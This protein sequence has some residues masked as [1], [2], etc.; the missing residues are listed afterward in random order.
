MKL[1][2]IID[3]LNR[4]RLANDL[5]A[6]SLLLL[7]SLFLVLLIL[8]TPPSPFLLFFS[9]LSGFFFYLFYKLFSFFP[10]FQSYSR[11]RSGYLLE[12]KFPVIK[13]KLIPAL[14]LAENYKK[15]Q[16]SKEAYSLTLINAAINEAQE[17]LKGLPINAIVNRPFLKKSA[18]AF[19]MMVWVIALFAFFFPKNFLFSFYSLFSPGRIPLEISISPREI[20]TLPNKEVQIKIAIRAPYQFSSTLLYFVSSSAERKVKLPLKKNQAVYKFYPKEPLLYYV[21][22]FN[23]LSE[24]G[25]IRINQPLALSRLT[26]F[27]QPPLYTSL[28]PLRI[29]FPKEISCLKGSEIK[30]SGA[31]NQKAD[32]SFLLNG[33]EVKQIYSADTFFFSFSAIK[34]TLFS[35]KLIGANQE[36]LVY[37]VKLNY[38]P[39]ENPFVRFL[40]PGEDRDIPESM[41]ILLYL[42]G[43]D[44]FGIKEISLFYQIK[45]KEI[46]FY[47]RYPNKKSDTLSFIWDLTKLNLLPGDEITYYATIKDNDPYGP[48]IS[49]SQEYKLRFPTLTEIYS[50]TVEKR[51]A[52]KSSLST[53]LQESEKVSESIEELISTLKKERKLSWEERRAMESALEKK[54]EIISALKKL[55]EEVKEMME[56]LLEG[57][58][59]D[60]ET[61]EKLEELEKLLSEILPQE[62]KEEIKKLRDAL[63]K[64]SSDL[65]Q[66]LKKMKTTSEELKRQL[67]RSIEILKR[68]QEEAKLSELEKRLKEI[69][70]NQKKIEKEMNQTPKEKLEERE[71]E[72]AEALKSWEEELK[73]LSL[74]EKEFQEI[75]QG[76]RKELEKERFSEMAEGIRD[77]ISAGKLSAARRNS[78]SL[79][80]KISQTRRQLSELAAGMKK[81]RRRDF[82]DRLWRYGLLLCEMAE[83]TKELQKETNEKKMGEELIKKSQG[84]KE[85]I[86]GLADSLLGLS[87]QSLQISPH[88]AD[89]LLKAI[90]ALEEGG[91][92]L[93]EKNY[94]AGENKFSEAKTEINNTIENILLLLTMAQKGGMS[95]SL[96]DFLSSLS[97]GLQEMSEI[98]SEMGGMPIPIPSPLSAEQLSALQRILGRQ[99]SLRERLEE[100]MKGLPEKPG[101]T[102]AMEGI[103]D[104]MKKIEEDMEKLN[105]TRE[106]VEREE[107]VFHRLLDVERSIRKKE[108][109]EKR[110]REVGKEFKI[111][112]RPILPKDLGE[113]KRV[114]QEELLNALRE[115]Y[116][117]EYYRLIKEYFDALLYEK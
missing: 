48:K 82:V 40:L 37:P 57:A 66:I 72:I 104:E 62:L 52:I 44:D 61:M 98:L 29:D 56:E 108:A 71:K 23:R 86:Q 10:F 33:R 6:F 68:L 76:I 35:I 64:R 92:L 28:P 50:Q 94:L 39:D 32:L 117:R 31:V 67:E 58:V 16:G 41:K 25:K 114:L 27:L 15:L 26:S 115:N 90:T 7:S 17:I 88:L 107:K 83:K 42:L 34:E 11:I 60:R 75:L 80:K 111:E 84:I 19:L 87:S 13:G 54:E 53:Q 51:E 1:L 77:E 59:Y 65:S 47:S 103:I 73:K 20:L 14:S 95:G 69:E 70:E 116:P 4:R 89:D 12:D 24:K 5:L 21:K 18:T 9:L 3:R 81:K 97:Q 105:I 79:R 93:F 106:L 43:L 112:E 8:T 101:L 109:E 96:E 113:K 46:K 91:N 63:Q 85:G 36:E 49:K 100:M 45:E 55:R 30:I 2:E 22:V 78:E 74:S 99:R 110:E 102:S 38:L